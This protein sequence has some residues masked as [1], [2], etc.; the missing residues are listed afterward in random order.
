MHTVDK[1]DCFPLS[2]SQHNILNLERALVGTSVNNISTTVRIRGRVDFALLQQSINRVIESDASL[3]TQLVRVDGELMQYHAPFL[4]EEFPVYDFSN[5]SSEGVE[6][7]ENAV[8]R[9]L[10]PLEEGPLYRFILFRDSETSGGIL[11]KLH[12]IISDGWSQVMLCNKIGKTYLE[13]LSGKEPT[14]EEATDYQ[15]HVQEEQDYL[16]SRAF[17]RDE[18]YWKRIAEQIGEPSS[19]KSVCGASVSPVGRRMSFELP[20]IINHAI[21]SYCQEK[22]VAPFAVFYMALAI[23]FKRNSG[24][25]RFTIGVPIFNRTNYAF[26]QS[27]GMFVTTLPFYNELQDEWTLNTFNDALMEN[28]YEMLR[29]Q[30][31]PFSKICEL[32]GRDGRLFNIALSYQDSKLYESRDASVLL[33]GR[34]HYCGYQAEQLTIH[35][36]NLKDHQQYAVDYDYLAQCFTES[37]ITAL[38]RNL[39]HILSEALADPDKPIHK[40]NVLSLEEKEQVLYT[41]NKTDKHLEE[42]SVYHRMLKN[43]RKYLNRAAIIHNGERMTYGTLLHRS[44]QFASAISEHAEGSNPLVAIMLPRK[45]DLP[46]AMIGA[47]QQE[48]AYLLLSDTLPAERIRTIL[49][50]SE[51]A[52]LITDDRGKARMGQCEIPVVTLDTVDECYGI[53]MADRQDDATPAGDKIAYV[54]YTSGSTG[55]PKGVEITQRNLLNLAQEMAPVYAQG[56]VLSVCNVGFDAFMLESIVALLCGR[57]IVFPA[58]SELESPE[59][60]ASLMNGYAV[61][62]F[63]MTPSRLSALL[64]NNAFRKVMWRMESIV[65]GG[66]HFPT[67]LLK[68][69]KLCTNARIY[70][71][72]GP[73]ET[74][75]A[76][77]M[78]ELSRADKITVGAP[79]GNYKMYVLDQW[80]NPLPIGGSGRLFIGGKGVGKGYRNRPDLTEKAFRDNPFVHLD[81][82]YDTGDIAYWTPSGEIVLTGRADRQVKLRGLRIELQEVS[83]CIEAFPGVVSAYARVCDINGSQT[84]GVYYSASCPVYETD[85]IAHAATYLPEYMIPAFFIQLPVLPVTANGK[86]DEASLPIPQMDEAEPSWIVSAEAEKILGIFKEVLQND[87]IHANSD[88]FLSGGN[89]L[90]AMQCV[91]QIEETMARRI[92]IA[93]LYAYRTAAKLAAYLTGE[94]MPAGMSRGKDELSLI[95]AG[96]KEKYPLTAVQQGMYVQSVLDP[97]G[98]AYHMPGAFKLEAQPDIAALERA[99]AALIREDAIFRTVF[100]QDAEGIFARI[101]DNADFRLETLEGCSFE[102]AVAN[103]L[104]PFDLSRAPLLRAGLWH[105]AND[106]W[107]LFVDSHHIIGDGMSTP[108]LLQRLDRA[109][110]GQDTKVAWDFYDYLNT[111]SGKED[112]L[113]ADLT[114]WTEHLADLPEQ[115]QLPGDRPRPKKFDYKGN[116]IEVL[117]TSSES[118]ACE[119]F[120]KDSGFSEYMLFL[121]AYGMLLSAVSGKN[122]MIIGTPVAG[123][124]IA[125]TANIC[126]PFIN[127]LPLRLRYNS[128]MTVQQWLEAVRDEVTRLLDH[129]NVTLENLIHALQLPHSEQNALYQVMITQSPVDESAFTLGG[130]KME[131]NPISTGSVK[132]DMIMELAKKDG[133]FALHFS[134]ATSLFDESTVAFYGRCMKH[135]VSELLKDGQRKLSDIR[136]M[137]A[138]DQ[139]QLI[140][141]PNYSATPFLNRPLHKI[142]QSTAAMKGSDTAV[143][144]HGQPVTYDQLEK[145]A[146]YIADF[147]D[148]KQLKQGQCVALC[149]KR[150]PDMIAAMYGA[151]KAGHPYMFMLD[152]FPEARLRYM[153]QISDAGLLLYDENVTLPESFLAGELG[154]EVC[155][156]PH[157]EAVD[158]RPARVGENDLVNVLFT[159]GSTGQPK[160]VM[161]RQRSVSNLYSQ[162]KDLLRNVEGNVLCSTN[163]VFDCFIVETLI[164][165]ALGRTV[166]LADEEEMMLPWKLANLVETYRTGVFEMTPARLNMCL[167]NEAFRNAAKY[168]RI[169]LL[170]GEVVTDALVNKFYDCSDGVLMNMYGPTEATV[171]TTMEPL[172]RG[173]HIT[174]GRPM[175]NNRAYVLDENRRPVL[176]TA[177]G[178]MYISGECLSAGYVGRPELTEASFVDDVY[179]PGEKMYRSGDLVRLRL[180][181]RY[182]YIGRKDAQV[183]LNGQRV[184]LSEIT[185]AIES[186][187]ASVQAATVAIK[188]AD[189]TMELCAFFVS[190][191]AELSV[192]QIYAA[193][194]RTLPAYMVP[195][196]ILR[197]ERMPMTATNKIDR[198]TLLNYATEGIESFVLTPAAPAQAPEQAPAKAAEAAPVSVDADYVLSVWNAVLSTPA[199]SREDSFFAQGGTS[200]AALTVLSRF[201]NDRLEMSLAEFYENPTAWQQAELLKSRQPQPETPAQAQD[202]PEAPEKAVEEAP[203][204][205]AAQVASAPQENVSNRGKSVLISGATGFFGIHLLRELVDSGCE[206][207][208][209]LMRDGN[210][211]RLADTLEWYFGAEE[212]EI[213]LSYITVVKGDIAKERLGMDEHSYQALADQIQ[214]IYHT[215]ADVRHYAADAEPYLQTN[216]GGTKNM[217]ALA[218]RA[219]AKLLH[220]STCSVAGEVT[221]DGTPGVRFTEND[222]DVG[223]VWERNIYVRSKYLAEQAVF[224]A[225]DEGLNAKIFRLG[226]LVG[227]ESDGKFQKNPETNAFYLTMKGFCQ[228]GAL[229][230]DA[231]GQPIDLMPIDLAAKE[232]L[233]LVNGEHTVYH[234]MNAVPPTLGEVMTALNK[235]SRIVDAEEYHRILTES[236]SQLDDVLWAVVADC[237]RSN[238]TTGKIQVTNTITTEALQKAGFRQEPVPVETVLKEF[239]RGE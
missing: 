63:A 84:L 86:I 169:V 88:Y 178:E 149:L 230:T 216:V 145:Q 208:F 98:F 201:Y 198:V 214:E 13:L 110:R 87:Q 136:L 140:D 34:W 218:K 2:L 8:T 193:I 229:P 67:E 97:D 85:L 115:L 55:E 186:V 47:L 143:I 156:L 16:G 15:L 26:K 173:E 46:A 170:G 236:W 195:S 59:R 73:S 206:R 21:F 234:I 109:Y 49:R 172:K 161:L 75:V 54:V 103:F 43:S 79:L 20:Q 122:D 78:K 41:F 7:W 175:T 62:F 74:A 160:G 17:G 29:H 31:Y 163:S 134:Y 118:R 72:Y 135:T 113:Q 5:T 184:E 212:R 174:I 44:A 146:S 95:R 60:L 147:I 28:W 228:I 112:I 237:V 101:L 35:L 23:Y 39:C 158:T 194:R 105:D 153:A 217:I 131:Y 157:G 232:V 185:V 40:L 190:D 64:A 111:V 213:L 27:T 24:A 107:Y 132:M 220:M 120:C 33:S 150:T 25:D 19:L 224:A 238:A 166:V 202:K 30:R 137:S 129:Q 18:A 57:T 200:M 1:K 45:F 91:M 133:N 32:A 171:F 223:Q 116:D 196:R 121:A 159:S 189:G 144:F 70:N 53:P 205:A 100:V 210:Q 14:L 12:H 199:T 180:D 77:S 165:L 204:Q 3:R 215:A 203:V 42:E 96:K 125:G 104:R 48:C 183:K 38:H 22:R 181:G 82:I 182:D 176:P 124:N 209:C 80:M 117:L 191:V 177:C 155:P 152:T 10:I 142:L 52:L 37:E 227:R 92:R 81:R 83:S 4:R 235:D 138:F 99:F 66:E 108:I 162:M 69:L 233:R 65:C 51:A 207:V 119:A 148:A 90:N 154:I 211:D 58:D 71:Q 151:L 192:E 50:Q 123:R 126:G 56:A 94:K 36:T 222:F 89:S 168:I 76:A 6:S 11:V 114:H 225:I 139:E 187:D 102:E 128:D 61:G 188:K 68:K 93:D 219:D 239:W 164:A 167:G 226:R 106:A 231:A 130:G 9:E 141:T 197:L 127:T 179:F 221:K